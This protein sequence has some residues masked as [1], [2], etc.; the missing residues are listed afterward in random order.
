MKH[1]TN[2]I[3]NFSPNKKQKIAHTENEENLTM[4]FLR[5][6]V[7]SI[8]IEENWNNQCRVL[9]AAYGITAEEEKKMWADPEYGMDV[10]FG[11]REEKEEKKTEEEEEEEKRK[12]RKKE[13]KKRGIDKKRK[14]KGIDKKN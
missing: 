11:N 8:P 3:S 7:I 5:Q 14:E 1:S 2:L 13:E 6:Y 4:D 9:K 12:K 10:I